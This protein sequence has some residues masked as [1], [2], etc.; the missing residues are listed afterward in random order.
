MHSGMDTQ[1]SKRAIDS[2]SH[3]I[4]LRNMSYQSLFL[5][6]ARFTMF[7]AWEGKEFIAKSISASAPLEEI[8]HYCIPK[9]LPVHSN[10]YL[11]GPDP[12]FCLSPWWGKKIGERLLS[13]LFYLHL[14]CLGKLESVLTHHLLRD[15]LPSQFINLHATSSLFHHSDSSLWF[16]SAWVHLYSEDL[17]KIDPEMK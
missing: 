2:Q 5:N 3:T 1:H 17:L 9:S 11:P 16:P 8:Q 13:P 15:Q 4:F 7:Q 14:F 6:G 10:I 12:Q